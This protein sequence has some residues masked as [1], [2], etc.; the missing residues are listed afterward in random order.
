MHY[1]CM[2]DICIRIE[3]SKDVES[4]HNSKKADN[5]HKKNKISIRKTRTKYKESLN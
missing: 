5:M 3:D 2:Y 1:P 4:K